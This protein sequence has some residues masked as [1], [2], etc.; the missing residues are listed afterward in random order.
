MAVSELI[1]SLLDS[2]GPEAARCFSV[3]KPTCQ[4]LLG[5]QRLATGSRPRR[6][7][8]PLWQVGLASV[9]FKHIA[10]GLRIGLRTEGF[11]TPPALC[12]FA[13]GLDLAEN[14]SLSG[15]G[16]P[17]GDL[18]PSKEVVGEP[19]HLFGWF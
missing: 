18:K 14:R 4:N 17:L 13:G 19:T 10:N 7:G 6:F 11:C 9:I 1:P 16:R 2:V 8:G 3:Q 5:K 15:S 12:R